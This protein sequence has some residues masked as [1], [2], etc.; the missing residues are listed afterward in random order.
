MMRLIVS[1]QDIGLWAA[2]FIKSRVQAFAPTAQKPFVLGLPTGGT[3]EGMYA[4]LCDFCRKGELNFQHIITFNM[5]EY[6]GLSAQDPQSYHSYMK[7]HLFNGVNLP[8]EQAHIL[9]GLADDLQQECNRY[10]QA[11]RQ[12]GG[13]H[14]FL[15]GVGRNG[16]LAFNEPGSSFSSRTRPVTLEPNTRQAN[17]RFF[18]GDVSRVP[19]QALSVGIGTVLDAKEILFL[20]SGEQKAQA[21]A[22]LSL[23]EVT[24]QWPITALKTHPHATLLVDEAAASLL[25]GYAAEQLARLRKEHPQDHFWQ[26]EL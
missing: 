23:G 4:Y 1:K 22:R 7:H 15:G 11:I 14:L 10:E 16:H 2:S 25:T 20:A 13:I 19:T 12:A 21:V 17:A 8:A 24:P 3:V 18:G 6:V 5:D 26:L 9:N